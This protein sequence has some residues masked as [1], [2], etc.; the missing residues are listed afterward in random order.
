[1]APAGNVCRGLRW[2]PPMRGAGISSGP[3]GDPLC[4][5]TPLR[6]GG[7]SR[8][9]RDGEREAEDREAGT[10]ERPLG[11]VK[12]G[13]RERWDGRV[14]ISVARPSELGPGE[15]AAWHSLQRQT[16]SL[17]SPFL[18][19]EFAVAVDRFRA[20]ARVGVLFDGPAIVGFFPFERRRLGIGVPIGAGLN[21]CQGLVH[22]PAVEWDP[23]DLLRACK[24][25]V[26]QFDHLV[27]GQRPFERYQ[28]AVEPSP[29][30]DLAD[31]FAVYEEKLRVKSPQ[32]CK[33][34]ARKARKLERESGQLDFAVD[35]RDMAALR[36]LMS[37]KSDQYRRNE[38][39]NVFD[40]PWIVDLVDYLFSTHSDQF[41]GLLSVLYAGGAP[42]A[43]HFGLRAGH[44]LAHWFPAYDARFGRQ[45]PGLIQHLRMAEEAAGLGI[46]LID[47]G[48]GLGRYKETLRS[49]D[50][51]VAEGVVARGPLLATAHHAGSALASQARR[52]IKQYPPLFRAADRVLRHYGRVA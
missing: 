10:H 40:R 15:I 38:W 13:D 17:A 8:A 29:V 16:A 46:R 19:P 45:S 48:T 4:Y 52:K 32:F 22:A 34:V 6:E 1:M 26:W 44:V 25:A 37:W 42:L 20:G 49:Y 36:A 50:L 27:E 23:Q 39:P 14:Q 35:S 24:I 12:F 7:C 9:A 3:A 2:A 30:I 33:D 47:L 43:A 31:G 28:T 11:S 18:C 41:G 21:D 51:L 5:R